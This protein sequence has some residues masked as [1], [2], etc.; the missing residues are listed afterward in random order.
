SVCA[1]DRRRRG[2]PPTAAALEY[3]AIVEAMAQAVRVVS[4]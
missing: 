4:W 1:D 3:P 2:L